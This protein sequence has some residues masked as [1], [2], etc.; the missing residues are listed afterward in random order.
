MKPKPKPGKGERYLDCPHYESCLDF[1][2]LQNWK[3]MNC[4]QCDYY[5]E[6]LQKPPAATV[7]QENARICSECGKNPTI[8]PNS[9]LCASCIGKKAWKDGK[10]KKKRPSKKKAPGSLKIKETAKGQD[11]RKGEIGQPQADFPAIFE[12]K[13][14]DIL[15]ELEKVAAD[16]VRTVDEQI[17]YIIKSYLKTYHSESVK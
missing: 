9:P 5:L 6:I 8:Q 1:A 17:I 7:K 13:Y 2:A 14:K 12:G 16:E 4:E 3:A 11:K 15:K 10:A